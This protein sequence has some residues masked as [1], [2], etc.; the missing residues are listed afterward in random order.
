MW[1][2]SFIWIGANVVSPLCRGFG[3]IFLDNLW[4][5]TLSWAFETADMHAGWRL[6]LQRHLRYI[7]SST[8]CSYRLTG[9][10]T[11]LAVCLVSLLACC[12]FCIVLCRVLHLFLWFVIAVTQLSN[13]ISHYHEPLTSWIA[14]SQEASG[15][16]CVPQFSCVLM[17]SMV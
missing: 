13:I 1:F 17:S 7:L 11:P 4:N 15:M 3:W 10:W 5:N 8:Y 2:H 14:S 16:C 9:S 6:G 12:G